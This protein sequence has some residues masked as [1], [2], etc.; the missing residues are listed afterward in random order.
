MRLATPP[1]EILVFKNCTEWKHSSGRPSVHAMKRMWYPR[2]CGRWAGLS[3]YDHP[4]THR[5]T[6]IDRWN[7]M[8]ISPKVM[9]GFWW[10]FGEV[11]RGLS[12]NGLDF[13]GD[14]DSFVDTESFFA[15]D[16]IYMLSAHMLSQFRLSVRPSVT[17]VD[18]S[19]TAEVRN[20]NFHHTVTPYL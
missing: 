4:R 19:K 3:R 7:C 16:S 10:F 11:G 12:A 6:F 5:L 9:Y 8:Y 14:S 15:H 2:D 1:S 18:Q 17:R 20:I 13:G